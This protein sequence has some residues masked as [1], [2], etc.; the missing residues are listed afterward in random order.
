[1]HIY[2][3]YINEDR[4]KHEVIG[5]KWKRFLKNK[6]YACGVWG[7]RYMGNSVPCA[8]YFCEHQIA[9]KIVY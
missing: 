4:G 7:S 1:M 2:A 9:L 8:Q 3:L 6:P 5:E